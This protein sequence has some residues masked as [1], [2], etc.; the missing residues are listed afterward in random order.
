MGLNY[1]NVSGSGAIESLIELICL[2]HERWNIENSIVTSFMNWITMFWWYVR[3]LNTNQHSC[4][5]PFHRL[6][7]SEHT[8][9]LFVCLSLISHL[10]NQSSSSHSHTIH[11]IFSI[12]A[13]NIETVLAIDFYVSGRSLIR[14]PYW[15]DIWRNF[16][17]SR[18]RVFFLFCFL[19]LY[20]LIWRFHVIV[21]RN[22]SSTK[23]FSRC[24][25]LSLS[26]SYNRLD[27]CFGFF[28]SK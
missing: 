10:Q 25:L 13:N 6:A 17:F 18:F 24:F 26:R 20:I 3:D 9:F 8:P 4:K 19:L 27:F 28:F 15:I 16:L 14:D 1:R 12:K 23:M 2:S 5:M 11:T 22:L 21:S 7:R